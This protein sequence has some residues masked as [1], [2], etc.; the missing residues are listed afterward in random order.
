MDSGSD[1]KLLNLKELVN[2]SIPETQ[3]VLENGETNSKK[4]K[5]IPKRLK[6]GKTSPLSHVAFLVRGI[7]KLRW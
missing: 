1:L 7:L 6:Y 3:V 5:N 4:Y 2:K